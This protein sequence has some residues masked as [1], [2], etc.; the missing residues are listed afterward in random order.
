MIFHK[1]TLGVLDTN[2]YILSNDG[3]GAVIVDPADD[4]LAIRAILDKEKLSSFT[5]LLTHGHLDHTGAVKDLQNAGAT[6]YMSFLDKP[7]IGDDFGMGWQGTRS[8]FVPDNDLYDGQSLKIA[9]LSI[10]VL[11]TPGHT[12][13]SVCFLLGDMLLS[14]DTLFRHFVGRTDLPSGNFETLTESIRKK[15]YTLPPKTRVYPGHDG[16]TTIRKE[17]AENQKIKK[18]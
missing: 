7:L 9:G 13:G 3:H 14:G 12:A 18:S 15:L 1:L 17:Q 6:A 2:C 4:Y 11:H 10:Q 16:E 5:V 8:I